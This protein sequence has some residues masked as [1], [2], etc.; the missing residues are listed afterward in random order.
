VGNELRVV[1]S[2]LSGRGNVLSRAEELGLEVNAEYATN[3]LQRIKEMESRGF[4]FESADASVEL[5]MRR[6]QPN[7]HPPFELLDFMVVVEHRAGR[8]L[9]AEGNVKLRV[10]GEVVHT[11]SEG[12]GPVNALDYALRKALRGHY[13]VIDSFH[14]ADYKVRILDGAPGPAPQLAY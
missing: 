4:H 6:A 14:L 7:Y 9:F 11:V 12:N 8:G 1:V 5:M 10:Q 13:P 2:E 3:I